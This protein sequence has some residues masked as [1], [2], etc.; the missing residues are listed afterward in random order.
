MNGKELDFYMR[1]RKDIKKWVDKNVGKDSKWS[2]Y[3][4]L[5]PDIFHLLCKLVV[6]ENVPKSKK[7]K[8]A[9][10]IAYFISPIDFLPEA[11]IGPIGYLD[12]ILVAAFVLN[13]IVNDVDPQIILRHWAG[14]QDI[15]YII[16]NVLGNAN[17]M[18]GGGL[19]KKIKNRFS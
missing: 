14:E 10:A 5:A 17:Q 12:D 9:A 16:K 6:D 7:V 4:L 13:D 2:G 11:L 3:I 15:L 1:I 19:W 8:L 18:L